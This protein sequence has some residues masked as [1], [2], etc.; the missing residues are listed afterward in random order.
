MKNRT[1]L[2]A[3]RFVKNLASAF[4]KWKTTQDT[5]DLYIEK[6]SKWHLTDE[7]WSKALSRIVADR[8]DSD[9]PTIGLVCEYLKAQRS[10][11][12][13]NSDLGWMTWRLAGKSYSMRVKAENGRWVWARMGCSDRHRERVMLQHNPGTVAEP[14][15]GADCIVILPDNPAETERCTREEAREAFT[16]GYIEAGGD[17][18]RLNEF[19]TALTAR[20][21][22]RL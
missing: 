5:I 10:V 17:P 4:G 9:F 19:F 11:P 3:T 21:E 13:E 12:P 22:V 18:S 20:K 7:Q 1:N 15:E 6:L 8:I 14:P 16:R 2:S